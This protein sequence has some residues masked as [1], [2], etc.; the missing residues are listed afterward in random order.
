VRF[1]ND[2]GGGIVTRL[3]DNKTVAVET[4]D[5]FEIPVLDTE[6]VIIGGGDEKLLSIIPDKPN[7]ENKK[8]SKQ[9]D[10]KVVNKYFE[11]DPQPQNI[12]ENDDPSGT[13]IG[14]YLA[15]VPVNEHKP[16]S[17]DLNLYIINDS[18]YRLFYSISIW[19]QNEVEPIRSGVLVPDSKEIIKTFFQ[20]ELNNQIVFNIQSL[21]YKNIRFIPQQPEFSDI[22]ISPVKL[23]KDNTFSE[24]DFFDENSY[25]ISIIDSRKDILIRSLT[26]E[27]IN[28]VI[29][30]KEGSPLKQKEKKTVL[31]E[32]EEVDL[33]IDELI[34]NSKG[35]PAG[36]IIQIQL[37]RFE[38]SL[39]G[40]IKNSNTR[41]MV[42]IHGIGNGKLKLE[43]RK[44]LDKKYQ[45]YKYQDASFKEYGYGATIVYIR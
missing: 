11:D 10:N 39:E 42:F 23:Y 16:T 13:S 37:A 33:H 30:Q 29:K 1:L 19:K 41:K 45:K 31:S 4:T 43:L 21:F 28:S 8:S 35:M 20:G 14:L 26:D 40:G 27:A 34:E 38:T 9:S 6:V 2:V 25:V 32:I 24:N 3:I 12:K 15:F 18:D 5:G 22:N 17:S 44:L 7:N 36:E